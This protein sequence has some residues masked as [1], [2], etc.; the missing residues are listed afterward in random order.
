[1]KKILFIRSDRFGEFLLSLP[2]IKLVKINYPQSK[3]YLLARK[4]N[5]KLIEGINFIDCFLEYKK[6][7]F[8]G[9]KGAFRLAK[10]LKRERIDCC[11]ILNSKKEFHLASF[12]GGIPL[13][14][15]YDR[16][17][18]FCLNKKIKDNKFLADKHE[19]EY[20]I[21]LVSLICKKSFI[22]DISFPVDERNSIDF[23]K[24]NLDLSC[25]Y[26]V[27]HPFSSNFFKRIDYE[28]WSELVSD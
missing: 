17:W 24:N 12:L 11:I 21:D 13:R 28:F 3:V 19:V 1:M 7:T 14:V 22:P 15:G 4:D 5:L 6:D 9:Y 25:K 16:K 10:I 20:N 2:A 27:I 8:L 26:L 18:K 23:L